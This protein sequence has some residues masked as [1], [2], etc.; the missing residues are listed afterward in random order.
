MGPP[1]S[2][3]GERTIALDPDTAETLRRHRVGRILERDL[4][5]AAYVD[6]DLV[7]A[8]ELG[9]HYYLESISGWF[10]RR[11]NAAGITT[12][13]LHVLRHTHATIALTEGV[14]LH[15]VAAR[16]G[17]DPTTIIKTYAHLLPRSDEEAAAVVA[18]AI[19]VDKRLTNDARRRA[20]TPYFIGVSGPATSGS[21]RTPCS[22]APS[23]RCRPCA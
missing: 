22:P 10:A 8:D 1:K 21:A 4:A 7:F 19:S 17:D 23:G 18:A 12:A 2:G 13:S 15:V 11:R 16:L 5:G 6:H 20:G 3:R 14:P 9:S